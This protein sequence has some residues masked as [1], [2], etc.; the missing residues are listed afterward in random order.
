LNANKKKKKFPLLFSILLGCLITLGLFLYFSKPIS[1]SSSPIYE[2]I[3]TVSSDLNEKI[4]QIDHSIYDS[5]FERG[6]KEKDIFFSK[7]I[8]RHEKNFEWNF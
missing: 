5:L 4:S 7:V 6:I 1:K 8:T 3:Y 2:E